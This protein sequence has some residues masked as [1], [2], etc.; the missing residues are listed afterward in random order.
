MA[1]ISRKTGIEGQKE[2]DSDHAERVCDASQK[3]LPLLLRQI[4]ERNLD[5]SQERQAA[6]L[7]EGPFSFFPFL[8]VDVFVRDNPAILDPDDSVAISSRQFFVVRHQDDKPLL[9][10]FLEQRHD[11]L[12]IVAVQCAGRLIGQN[13]FGIRYQSSGY[14]R[15]LGL[16][17]GKLV[18][19][20]V[21]QIL[22]PDIAKHRQSFF[23]AFGIRHAPHL[24]GYPDI[25]E[26]LELRYQEI[27]LKDE[28]YLFVS[29]PIPFPV[30]HFPKRPAI[31]SNVAGSDAVQSAEEI[32]E[33]CLSAP[34]R[35]QNRH[36]L[37]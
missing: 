17:T 25:V 15:P 8:V 26:N 29:I 5:G 2:S 35:S 11:R 36:E 32:E 12:G 4:L 30:V 22:D 6:F 14:G 28:P 24:Q 19:F 3:S 27:I 9:A 1:G 7:D 10:L 21:G 37:N 33:R 34:G 18:R 31:D 23:T 20:F 16:P 13:D